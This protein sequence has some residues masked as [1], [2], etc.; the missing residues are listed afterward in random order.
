M[1]KTAELDQ[2]KQEVELEQKSAAQARE[3]F[4]HQQN[5]VTSLEMQAR[6]MGQEACELQRLLA[7]KQKEVD[8]EREKVNM[9]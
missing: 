5:L 7:A 8:T 4:D 2:A 1:D 6:K 3:A 9:R